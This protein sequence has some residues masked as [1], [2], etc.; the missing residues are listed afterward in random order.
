MKNYLDTFLGFFLHFLFPYKY[1]I[2]FLLFSMLVWASLVSYQPYILKEIIDYVVSHEGNN[3]DLFEIILFPSI[4]YV[5]LFEVININYRLFD[6]VAM[7]IMPRIK[8]DIR[9]IYV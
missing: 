9:N 8:R 6:Y 2:L 1:Q 5:A 4:I 3:E 7:K